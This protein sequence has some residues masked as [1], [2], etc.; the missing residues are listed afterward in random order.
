V[1]QV[2]PDIIDENAP[3]R[4]PAREEIEAIARTPVGMFWDRF[5]RDRVA[6]TGAIVIV[7]LALIALTAPFLAHQLSGR[8]PNELTLAREMTDEFGL[9]RGPNAEYWFGA[10]KAG[11]DLFV[12]V[13][14]GART[15]LLVAL[16]ATSI[17]V[18]VGVSLGITAGYYGGPIDTFISRTIDIILSLPLLLFAIG[19]SAACSTTK[20]GCLGGRIKPGL[21]LVIFIIAVFSWPYVARI[22]RGNTL[23]LREREFIDASRAL[24]A[25]G[26]RIM[27]KEILPN[28]IAPIIV[29][30][31]LIIP[32]NIVFEAALSYLGIGVPPHTPSWG[33][34]LADATR[35]LDVAPWLMIFPAL[36]LIL[37][38]L[39][40][41]LLG[42]GLR[43]ALDPKTAT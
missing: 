29:Y 39:A 16:I 34:M 7:L 41:S 20:D 37:T 10:D 1:A 25:S 38:T 14:Y 13:L 9:P 32:Q 35:L 36:F 4:G 43:D 11:R 42:D 3:S 6:I 15:S 17:S 8:G 23:S 28:L 27:F 33:R 5:R 30:A 18:A 21:G 26:R 22:V 31:T 2:A 12:R 40:F 19:I 24:G